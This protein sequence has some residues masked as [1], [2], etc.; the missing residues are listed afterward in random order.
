MV[1]HMGTT[2]IYLIKSVW[3]SLIVWRHWANTCGGVWN[4]CKHE[5][6]IQRVGTIVFGGCV[7]CFPVQVGGVFGGLSGHHFLR[8][9]GLK[10]EHV[11]ACPK[12]TIW[13][14]RTFLNGCVG[15]FRRT[16]RLSH[17]NHD[18][19]NVPHIITVYYSDLGW[20][21]SSRRVCFGHHMLAPIWVPSSPG[22]AS[23]SFRPEM[24]VSRPQTCATRGQKWWGA[25]SSSTWARFQSW[26]ALWN[27]E[28]RQPE[29]CRW[30]CIQRLRNMKHQTQLSQKHPKH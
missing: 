15:V 11:S 25:G 20:M 24:A 7:R 14:V 5:D 28:K 16:T 22:Q 26:A 18:P 2:G 29:A 9:S 13:S 1:N 19:D 30:C 4:K 6:F 10:T 21:F 23:S 3:Y 8:T 17:R 12:L 27:A